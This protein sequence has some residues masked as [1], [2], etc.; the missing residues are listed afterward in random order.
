MV[1]YVWFSHCRVGII[2]VPMAYVCCAYLL[3]SC[4]SEPQEFMLSGLAR[5]GDSVS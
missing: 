2:C 3:R 5:R 1:Q 4:M